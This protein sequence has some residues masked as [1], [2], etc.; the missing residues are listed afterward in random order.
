MIPTLPFILG[1]V[2]GAAAVSVLRSERGR[3]LLGSSAQQLRQ[4]Y[5]QA[6]TQVCAVARSGLERLRAGAQPGEPEPVAP[7]DP[8]KRRRSGSSPGGSAGV[9]RSAAKPPSATEPERP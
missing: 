6:E 8:P 9:R 1:L 3:A 2:A 7:I 4:T 5:A